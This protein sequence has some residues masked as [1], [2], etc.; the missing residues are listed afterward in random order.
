MD[1]SVCVTF[2]S[3]LCQLWLG[4][5]HADPYLVALLKRF[6]ELKRT[7]DTHIRNRL[8]CFPASPASCSVAVLLACKLTLK[9]F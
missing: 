4:S 8:K 9:R 7:K 1:E 2:T 3:C 6:G 5:M